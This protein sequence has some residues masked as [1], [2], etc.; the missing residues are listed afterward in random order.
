MNSPDSTCTWRRKRKARDGG[1]R[2]PEVKEVLD[3]YWQETERVHGVRPAINFPRE[4]ALVK[5]LLS[6]GVD[7]SAL[8]NHITRSVHTARKGETRL[9]LVNILVAFQTAMQS[10]PIP[11]SSSPAVPFDEIV[12]YLNAKAGSS[13]K[14]TDPATMRMIEA[15]WA[16]GH[17]FEDFRKVIDNMTAK[18]G[19][20][21]KMMSFL[22][23]ATLFHGE[24]FGN[25]LG[26]V[27]TPVDLGI[28]SRTGYESSLVLDDWIV[29]KRQELR[30]RNEG[31][32]GDQEGQEEVSA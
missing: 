20:N 6:H 15:R 22:R 11:P 9:A 8:K 10:Q 13:Y 17:R 23:P 27:V 30:A 3:H 1:E 18:W 31:G 24:K 28:M 16:E 7:V 4:G 26:A 12:G 21:A 19:K 25:Y 2:M 32:I 5:R 29:Q 14:P